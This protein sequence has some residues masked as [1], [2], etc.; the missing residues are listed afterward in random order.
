MITDKLIRDKFVSETIRKGIHKIYDTQEN[1]VRN[2]YQLRTGRLLTAITAHNF[3]SASQGY[4]HTFFVRILPYLRF[5]DMGYR[6]R[7]DRI[8][9]HQRAHLALYNRVVWGVLYHETF[10]E[11]AYGF[12]DEVRKQVGKELQDIFDTDT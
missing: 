9:K 11:I 5:L 4:S 8:A 7:K 3:T 2:N 1:V 10:P 12:T 6:L